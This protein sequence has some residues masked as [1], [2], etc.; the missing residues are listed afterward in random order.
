MPIANAKTNLC[1]VM[2]L[3]LIGTAG[4]ALPCPVLAPLFLD[5]PQ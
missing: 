2:L 4:I 5:G 3:T 1:A